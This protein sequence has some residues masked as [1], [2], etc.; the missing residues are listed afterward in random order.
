MNRK[1]LVVIVIVILLAVPTVLFITSGDFFPEKI[2]PYNVGFISENGQDTVFVRNGIEGLY[3]ATLSDDIDI[4]ANLYYSSNLT[5]ESI[6]ET[7]GQAIENDAEMIMAV[8]YGNTDP[9]LR[10]AMLYSNTSFVIVDGNIIDNLP[11][12]YAN[13]VFRS[14]EPSFIAGYIAGKMTRTGIIGF[15]GGMPINSVQR[16]Y[17][18]YSAG[19]KTA[20]ISSSKKIKLLTDY[21]NSFSDQEAGFNVAKTM[22]E[23]GADIIFAVA[24]DSGLGA[25]RA[26]K[27][28]DKYIIGVDTD[29]NYLAPLNVLFS[30]TK[31][32]P[33]TVSNV[34]KDYAINHMRDIAEGSSIK[35]EYGIISIGYADNGVNI[36]SIIDAVPDSLK[37]EEVFI[38]RLI[39]EGGLTIPATQDEYDAW[40]PS[41]IIFL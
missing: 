35:N 12:N 34:V 10:G 1:V 17:Y 28:L 2:K 37:V 33:D 25:I 7:I 5:L 18:G 21:T 13:I 16:F 26:A 27:E 22:Y 40:I 36:E 9:M 24:G 29:Q 30:V 19:V 8:G 15:L 6:L 14:N 31:N 4:K 38:E 41:N 23:N 3:N 39:R 11:E 32:I 20:E